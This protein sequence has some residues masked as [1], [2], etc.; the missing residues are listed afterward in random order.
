[1][2]PIKLKDNAFTLQPKPSPLPEKPRCKICK[3]EFNSK[4]SLKI[5]YKSKIHLE[6]CRKSKVNSFQTL[7]TSTSPL[8]IDKTSSASIDNSQPIFNSTQET[9]LSPGLSVNKE[10][11]SNNKQNN[12]QLKR[13]SS[14]NENILPT[15]KHKPDVSEEISS[16]DLI[17]RITKEKVIHDIQE[18]FETVLTGEAVYTE[19]DGNQPLNKIDL[20]NTSDES[21]FKIHFNKQQKPVKGDCEKYSQK[22]YGFC[23]KHFNQ[24]KLFGLPNLGNTCYMNSIVQLLF[25]LPSFVSVLLDSMKRVYLINPELNLPLSQSL[26]NDQL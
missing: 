10:N 25:N 23:A 13:N 6:N 5:H 7:S 9:T 12:V 3:K 24:S 19:S 8:S 11:E 4:K 14:F 21:E 16:D 20:D 17:D 22:N 15:K 2:K 1:M 18:S 26:I